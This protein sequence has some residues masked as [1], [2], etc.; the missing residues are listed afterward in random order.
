MQTEDYA[1][2]R[3][4]IAAGAEFVMVGH[5]VNTAVDKNTP[6]TLSRYYVTDVLR[7]ELGFDGII[8][9]DSM[10]MGAITKYFGTSDAYVKAIQAGNDML[11]MPGSLS[12]AVSAVSKAV[13]SG[14]IS[15]Q[16]IND[17]VTRILMLKEQK[18]LL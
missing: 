7:K 14:Q 3:A 11:L 5:V 6:A 4:G 2:F 1:P 15:E 10:E 18:G 16:Q 13:R 9:T 17:S 12:T 8:V